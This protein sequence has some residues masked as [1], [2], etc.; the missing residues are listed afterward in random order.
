MSSSSP[1]SSFSLRYPASLAAAAACWGVATAVSKQAVAQ[2]P[3]LLLLAVQL[4]VSVGM[5]LVLVRVQ[6]LRIEWSSVTFRLGLLGVLNPGLSYTLALLGLARITA[7]LSVLLWAVEPILIFGL[8]WAVLGERMKPAAL[9]LALAAVSGVMLM[10]A[11]RGP[12]GGSMSGVLLTLGGVACCAVYTVL[13]R[14]HAGDHSTLA[15]VTVQQGCALVWAVSLLALSVAATEPID[16]AAVGAGAWISAAL[17]GVIYYAVAFWFYLTGLRRVQA[18]VA[19]ISINLI[20]VFGIGAGYLLLGEALSTIQ[21][22]GAVVI[23]ASVT[24]IAVGTK[25]TQSA[26]PTEP[27]LH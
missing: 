12:G 13:A 1:S 21:W 19:G 25:A 5:L 9:V 18:W 16:L 26:T 8:A 4:T 15:V 20:P 6:R 27:T 11:G 22:I 24:A 17:S 2:I 7:S 14:K 3:P 23:V 10:V